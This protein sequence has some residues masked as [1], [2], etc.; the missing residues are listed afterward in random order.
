[1]MNLSKV[2]SI[3]VTYANAN[4]DI[5]YS[6]TIWA[7]IKWHNIDSRSLII[8]K[9]AEKTKFRVVTQANIV[10]VSIS[11]VCR[12]PWVFP[13]ANCEVLQC[14]VEGAQKFSQSSTCSVLSC[15]VSTTEGIGVLEANHFINSVFRST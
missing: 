4:C 1:M 5:S 6:D 9:G 11:R 13:K 14:S 8:I 10:V 12:A 7:M 3:A 2:Y 15:H